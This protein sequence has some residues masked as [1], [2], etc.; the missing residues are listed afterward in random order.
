VSSTIFQRPA[1]DGALSHLETT[2]HQS[3]IREQLERI[4]ESPGFR[5]SKRYPN[6]LRHVVERALQ[7]RTSDLKERTLGIDV[8]GRSPDYD[9]AADP[10]VRVSAGEI[11][12]R[13]AQYYHESGHEAEIRIDL[14]LGSYLPEFHFP[15]LERFAETSVPL[16]EPV[17]LAP[18]RGSWS[19]IAAA[20]ASPKRVAAVASV[21]VA[22]SL[23]WFRPWVK[24]Q[25]VLDQ[26]WAPVFSPSSRVVLCVGRAPLA[27]GSVA[28]PERLASRPN[29]IGWPDVLT[30]VRISGLIQSK[31]QPYQILREDRAS[32]SELQDGPAILIGAF[33]DAWT[34]RLMDGMRFGYRQDGAVYQ[35]SDRQDP[36]RTQWKTDLSRQDADGR[37]LVNQDYALISRFLNPRTGRIVVIVAGLYGFG[38][39]AAGRFLTDAHQME[40]LVG[41]VP[42]EW[43]KKNLQIVVGTEVIDRSSGPA[44]VLA[45]HSW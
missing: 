29:S 34:L 37:P 10:V 44:R 8:F 32:F 13:I 33:N 17:M 7:G 22:I 19:F 40:Q 5:N 43:E 39:E 27:P 11:R 31:N 35:I 45:V 12:K 6:L 1:Q 24:H 23:A 4:L 16:E 20:L 3:A 25:T 36:S 15:R 41:Q 2:E 21:L 30:L 42:P 26:F 9:P 38:T 14:P 18:V 28:T